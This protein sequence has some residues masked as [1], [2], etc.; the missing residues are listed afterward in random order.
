MRRY[1]V[2]VSA[3][4]GLLMYSIDSTAV[5]VAFPNFMREFNANVLWA[6]WTISIYYIGTTTAMPLAGN[7]S[8]MF[9]RKKV[10][11]I[12]LILFTVGSLACGFAPNMYTLIVFRF[13]QGIGGASFLP[14]ASGIVADHFPENRERAIGLFTSIFPI[15]GIIGP[16]LGGWIVSRFSWRYIFYINLPVGICLTALI[17]VLL[18]DTR[19]SSR[20]RVDFKGAL[21]MSGTVLFLMFGLNIVAENFSVRS[22]LYTAGFLC[23]SFILFLLFFRQ[24][25]REINP[26]LDLSLLRSKPFLAANLLNMIIGAAGFGIFSFV[27]LLATSVYKLSTLMSGMILTPRSIGTI[28]SSAVTSFLLKRCGYRVPMIVGLT[29][30]SL[31]TIIL[32][33]GQLWGAVAVRIGSAEV[34][35][36]LILITG[37]GMGIAFPAA[38]NACIELMP[39]KV[40]SIVGLRGMFRTVGGAL[41]ISIITLILH[42]SVSPSTGFKITFS[43]FGFGLLSSIP[44]VMLMPTGKKGWG[45]A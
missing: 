15:G 21:L 42:S 44:L 28:S 19:V 9:G 41:G 12:S 25:R 40:A 32:G 22:L 38:N 14:T 34:L 36:I 11:L 33:Q 18:R 23:L 35:S 30:I 39:E 2:F 37:V 17:L 20:P 29:I 7:L 4:L 26:I 31:T 45:G 5:A 1:L 43:I 24:E 10:F 3:A 8:D 13:F 6:A 27:P 16:N